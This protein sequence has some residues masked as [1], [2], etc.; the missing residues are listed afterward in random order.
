MEHAK[1]EEIGNHFRAGFDFKYT[2]RETLDNMSNDEIKEYI[3]AY[4]E[5]AIAKAKGKT[6]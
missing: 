2:F 1:S 5:S 3:H 6:T 4:A